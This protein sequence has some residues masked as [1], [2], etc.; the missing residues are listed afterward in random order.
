MNPTKLKPMV[1]MDKYDLFCMK[2]D[3]WAVETTL[4]IS[5]LFVRVN[6][7]PPPALA[8]I[9]NLKTLFRLFPSISIQD[10]GH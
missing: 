5:L 9:I 6:S 2:Q 7:Q 4:Y 10:K 3:L 1:I 8:V